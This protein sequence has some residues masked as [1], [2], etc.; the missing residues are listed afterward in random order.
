[1]NLKRYL[2]AASL[3]GLLTANSL[4]LSGYYENWSQYRGINQSGS[5]RGTFPSCTPNGFSTIAKNLS[6]FNYAFWF[7]N[8]DATNKV[9]TGDWKAYP[10]EW[11]DITNWGDGGLLAQAA[12]LKKIN[13]NLKTMLT[14]GGWSFID[15]GSPYG[16]TTQ[17][18]FTQ[19]LADSAKQTKFINSLIDPANG[20]FFQKGPD[21]SYL[22]DGIDLDYEYPGQLSL[23]TGVAGTAG[24]TNNP[25]AAG[26]YAGFITFI[27]ALRSA[28]NTIN[29]AGTR[30]PLYLSITPPPFMP[31]YLAAGSSA[32]SGS[33][34]TGTPLHGTA[35]SCSAVDPNNPSTYF[36]WY[37]IVANHCDWVNIMTYDMYGA[38]SSNIQFQ[39][40]LYNGNQRP[41][42]PNVIPDNS[43]DQA[44]SVDYALWMWSEGAKAAGTGLGIAPNQI[45]LGL[46][47]YGRSYGGTSPFA[48]NPIG[49]IN[50]PNPGGYAQPYTQQAGVAAY[51]ELISLLANSAT[52]LG[53]QNPLAAVGGNPSAAQS[54]LVLNQTKNNPSNNVFVFDSP[55]NIQDKVNYAKNQ[56]LK[57]V[58][59]YALSEDNLTGTGATGYNFKDSLFNAAFQAVS[60]PGA[61][62]YQNSAPSNGAN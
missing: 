56:G 36:G 42:N 15:S 45:R 54:F 21:G 8:Y 43:N 38:F 26:D 40:P 35:Y 14:I 22:C 27:Q 52:M 24:V 33:Y 5:N 25:N 51:F 46:P 59:F 61:S 28:I 12:S 10:T 17:T 4:E 29:L 57:G 20:Y 3:T 41:Y 31:P 55:Q 23:G 13:N 1:M 19:L 53:A 32:Y 37:S 62:T 34:P 11:N 39:A 47:A 6:I 44:Y 16:G 60:A 48:S 2:L 7:F 18:F 58:F 49:G 30:P 9:A 50:P